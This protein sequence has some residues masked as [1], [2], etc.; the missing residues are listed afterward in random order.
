[1]NCLP[2]QSKSKRGFGFTLVEVTLALGLLSFGLVAIYGLLPVGLST[3]R[4]SVS[5][6]VQTTVTQSI[7]T[8]VHQT[9]FSNITGGQDRVASLLQSGE[10][11]VSVDPVYYY[12]DD[13][14]TRISDPRMSA[15]TAAAWFTPEVSIPA[16]DAQRVFT[17]SAGTLT[18]WV[19]CNRGSFVGS[20]PAGKASKKYATLVADMNK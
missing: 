8:L 7:S 15:Y 6:T 1:M 16:A 13:E 18:L 9:K 5:D 19:Y 3:F 20:K 14:G 11:P 2:K 4:E 10:E 12:F 17:P